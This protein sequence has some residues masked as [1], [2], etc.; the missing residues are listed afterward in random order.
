M[1]NEFRIFIYISR[2]R[3][4][5]R[6]RHMKHNNKA[7][8][9]RVLFP[10]TLNIFLQRCCCCCCCYSE[11]NYLIFIFTKNKKR[12]MISS[13]KKKEE[14]NADVMMTM[15]KILQLD[16]LNVGHNQSQKCFFFRTREW[17]WEMM[18]VKLLN[19]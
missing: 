2:K 15:M 13:A 10:S 18:K 11:K 16:L 7:K 6:S 14:R 4:Q 19:F 1:M 9:L 12:K 5:S 17:E 3:V 8:R